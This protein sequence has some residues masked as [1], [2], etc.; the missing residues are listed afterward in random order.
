VILATERL[1]LRPPELADAPAVQRLA[2]AR[3]VA[4]NTLHIPHPYPDGAAEAWI[5]RN[6]N[7]NELRFAITPRDSGE[8]AGVIG[9]IVNRDHLRAEIGYWIGVPY[10]GRGYA[11]EA[12]RAVVRYAF[13]ELGLNRVY[14]EVFSRNPASARV[15]Q[16][17]GMRH[18]GTH[19]AH[20]VKWGEA[21]DVEMYGVLRGEWM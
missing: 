18:E 19:R 11:A 14:A 1:I 15:L 10:W 12:G 21:V 16:K 5:G 6:P 13:G 4:L 9:L 17:I 3:E 7:E 2:G 8:L 20:I